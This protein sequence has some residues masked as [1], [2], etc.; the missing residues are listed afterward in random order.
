MEKVIWEAA[1]EDE[2]REFQDLWMEKVGDMI[3]ERK[4]INNWLKI[5]EKRG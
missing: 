2:R 3:L 5:K 4:G 1:K